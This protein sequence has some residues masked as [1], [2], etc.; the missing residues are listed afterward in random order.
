[1]RQDALIA[2]SLLGPFN[3]DDNGDN[4]IEEDEDEENE[5]DGR[6]SRHRSSSSLLSSLEYL[7]HTSSDVDI[8][9]DGSINAYNAR[10]GD[11]HNNAG[12]GD[13][14]SKSSPTLKQQVIAAIM[15]RVKQ[16]GNHYV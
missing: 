15:Q 3:D 1:M 8:N 4:G 14:H 2:E 10:K 9:L 5:E 7:C 6:K 13:D 16:L 12:K 11:D